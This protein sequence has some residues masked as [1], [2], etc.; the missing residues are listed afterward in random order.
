MTSSVIDG[1]PSAWPSVAPA[2]TTARRL[3]AGATSENT[4]RSYETG[5]R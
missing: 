1:P 4:R 2:I 5:W 3:I